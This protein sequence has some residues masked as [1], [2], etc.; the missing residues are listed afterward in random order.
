MEIE[1]LPAEAHDVRMTGALTPGRGLV[2]LP[3]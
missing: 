3:I 1:R 2:R